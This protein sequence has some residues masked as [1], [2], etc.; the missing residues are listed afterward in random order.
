MTSMI[1]PYQDLNYFEK[2]IVEI[3]MDE[4]NRTQIVSVSIV[5]EYQE[6]L[7]LLDDGHESANTFA[8]L[9]NDAYSSGTS[10]KTWLNNIF[11][12]LY[13]N[14][15]EIRLFEKLLKDNNSLLI[16]YLEGITALE[17][18]SYLQIYVGENKPT[19]TFR[20]ETFLVDV[21]LSYRR[22]DISCRMA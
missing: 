2:H 22:S 17:G 4:F 6:I 21:N 7:K 15:E 1:R 12:F 9:F 19:Q 3:L 18:K 8:H 5:N 10:E 16:L 20:W 11:N 13:T 14:T